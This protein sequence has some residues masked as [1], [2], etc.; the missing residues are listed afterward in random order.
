LY[1]T[2]GD[3]KAISAIKSDSHPFFKN[4]SW[5][6]ASVNYRGQANSHQQVL[7][8]IFQDVI[9][10]AHPIT[11]FPVSLNPHFLEWFLIDDHYFKKV[12]GKEGYFELLYDSEEITLYKKHE[13]SKVFEIYTDKEEEKFKYVLDES[14]YLKRGDSWVR[15]R[16]KKTFL[17]LFAE[18]KKEINTFYKNKVRKSE[19]D[20]LE[21]TALMLTE[22]AAKNL[23]K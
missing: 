8:D 19:R 4:P 23:I 10:L 16:G 9:F 21:N 22:F 13:K 14:F 1:Q 5:V 18:H 6:E 12:E 7:Y 15:I 20:G 3:Y 11:S 17:K 2:T